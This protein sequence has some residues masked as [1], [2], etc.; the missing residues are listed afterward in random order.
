MGKK[1]K[2]KNKQ[3]RKDASGIGDEP[4]EKDPMID[5]ILKEARDRCPEAEEYYPVTREIFE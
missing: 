3:R 5:N 1:S 4:Y 2:N